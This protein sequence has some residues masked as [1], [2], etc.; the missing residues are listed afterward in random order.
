MSRYNPM[1]DAKTRNKVSKTLKK[2]KHKPK[3][4]GGNG[5]GPTEYENLLLKEL[6][7]IDKSFVG[8]LVEVTSAYKKDYNCPNHYKI[9]IASKA[10]M[11]AIE[12]DGSSHSSLKVKE[13]DKRKDQVLSLIG[14]RVLRLSNDQIE[15]E[16]KNCVQMALSMI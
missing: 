4:Q 6:L 1:K 8:N 7:K 5:R 2:I 9:D 10:H 15:K 11:I 14:W 3:V 13:C 16:L 12:V